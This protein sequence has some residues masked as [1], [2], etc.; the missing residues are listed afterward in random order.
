[1]A[2]IL[3]DYWRYRAEKARTMAYSATV[4]ELREEVRA[5]A[6]VYDYL[7]DLSWRFSPP[8]GA[9]LASAWH[10][11]CPDVSF[12]QSPSSEPKPRLDSPQHALEHA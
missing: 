7:G 5:M 6:V 1:M 12:W 11:A 8:P 3:T 10:L 9:S 2:D 4:E